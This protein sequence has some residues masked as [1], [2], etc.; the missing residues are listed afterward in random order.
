M[1]S[2]V[3]ADNDFTL[4]ARDVPPNVFGLFFYGPN[5]VQ[6]PFGNGFR[7][8]GGMIQRVQPAAQANASGVTTRQLDLLSTPHTSFISPGVTTNFQLWFRDPMGGGLA[9]NTTDGVEVSFR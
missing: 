2:N 1:G 6:V 3:V 4:E 8:V 5:Q 9:F 7:C